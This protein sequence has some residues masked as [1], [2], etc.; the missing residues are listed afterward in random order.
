MP[1]RP[2][3]PSKPD[4]VQAFAKVRSTIKACTNFWGN[5]MTNPKCM[6]NNNV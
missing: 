6:C 5:A 2:P 1:L 3:T 4:Y